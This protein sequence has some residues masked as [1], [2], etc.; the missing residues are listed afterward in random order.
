MDRRRF[1]RTTA[2]ALPGLAL[3]LRATGAAAAPAIGVPGTAH[4]LAERFPDLRRHFVFEYYPWYSLDPLLHWDMSDRVPPIDIAANYMPRLGPY[5]SLGTAVLEQH[6]RW[7][8]ESGAG[9]VNLSWWG[10]GSF[11]DRAVHRVMDVMKAFDLKVAFTLEPY[12]DFGRQR[13]DE[14]VLYLLREYGEKRHFDALL[15]LANEDGRRGPVF[16][17]FACIIEPESTDCHGV[18]RTVDGF[19]PDSAW[20]RQIDRLR[21]TL[22]ADYDHLTFLADSLEFAR[23]P[24]SGFDGVAIYDVVNV[25]PADY[26]RHAQA[27]SQAGLLFSFSINAGFDSLVER[28]VPPDSCYS[29]P[30]FAPAGVAPVDF[31]R[32][33]GRE[34][35]ALQATARVKESFEATLA[36]QTDPGLANAQRGFFLAYVTTFNEW[37]EGTA[38]EPMRDAAALS[39]AERAV[40]YHNPANGGYRLAALKT[41][42]AG[43]LDPA[44]GASSNGARSAARTGQA[45]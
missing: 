40:G 1:L 9:S 41:L 24:A 33:D 38:F 34:A 12:E 17:G 30:P 26:A 28:V 10:P 11:E 5:D 21:T 29:P 35:A 42:L 25:P 15:L 31:S 45:R 3:G 8:V 13:F 6:A 20:R 27:A 22:R 44:I 39:P 19:T 43:V 14:D 16:K 7:I 18:T 37:H 36:V 32:A 4:P 23:T 2:A